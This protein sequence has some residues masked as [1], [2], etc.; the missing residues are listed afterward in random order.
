MP[1]KIMKITDNEN[2]EKPK[3]ESETT[4]LFMC[5]PD[6]LKRLFS[7]Y[8]NELVRLDATY[9]TTWYHLPLFFFDVKTHIDY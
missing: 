3:S 6:W 1:Q 5:Q 8:G 9:R 7:H 4:L 2:K